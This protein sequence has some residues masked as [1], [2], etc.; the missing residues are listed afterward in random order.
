MNEV[1]SSI[2]CLQVS[3]EAGWCHICETIDHEVW[4]GRK[5][6]C[7][8]EGTEAMNATKPQLVGRLRLTSRASI[9]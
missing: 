3:A 4:Q 1:D 5:G 6:D 9:R 8:I 7:Q 2:S